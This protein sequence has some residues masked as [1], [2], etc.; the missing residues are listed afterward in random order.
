MSALLLWAVGETGKEF[1]CALNLY[2]FQKDKERY[3]YV[4]IH[5]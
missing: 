1:Y 2:I 4:I 3:F 5:N